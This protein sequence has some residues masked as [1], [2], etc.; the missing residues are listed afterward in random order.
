[1]IRRLALAVALSWGAAA[2]AQTSPIIRVD[3]AG[4]G[5]GPQI[6][7]QALAAPHRVVPPSSERFVFLR[8]STYRPT[9]IVLGRDAVV[10]GRVE[11]DVIIVAGDLY[12]HPGAAITGRVVAIDGGVYESMLATIGGRVSS[13]RHFTYDV[14]PVDGGYSLRYREL[15]P[16][17]DAALT[18]PGIYGLGL[19]SYDRTNGLS[20]GGGPQY[21]VPGTEVVITPELTYRSQLGTIDPSVVAAAQLDRRTVARVRAERTTLSN[22][23]WI[24]ANLLNSALFLF[25]GDDTR[26]YY[27][28]TRALVTVERAWES[29]AGKLVPYVGVLHERA[30]SVRPG[31]F[32][33][34]GPWT[35]LGRKD[36]DRTHRL[37]ENPRVDDDK[38]ITS[39]VAGAAWDWSA[40]ELTA[41]AGA[42]VELGSG[43]GQLTFDGHVEFPTF[44]THALSI[45]AHLVTSAGSRT[46]RQRYAYVGGS[47]TL[48]TLDL[49]SEGG[50]ELFFL[51][52][53]Y[54]IPL[55]VVTLPFFGQP[56]LTLRDMLGGARV[57]GFPTLHQAIGARLAVGPLYAEFLIDPVSRK[58]HP[59]FGLS[60]AR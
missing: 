53:A 43:F 38:R 19:P 45:A 36:E 51:D 56:V 11:G 59:G 57:G 6:L 17:Q 42:D 44:R 3:D 54:A 52:A 50:D 34:G 7:A 15:F 31:P 37:R 33:T 35:M 32:A 21:V 10:E 58:T 29:A 39:A 49:L 28:S 18:W 25:N 27:R 14:T 13:F 40:N 20:I 2:S 48:S 9:T 47:G 1:V 5:V 4:P 16:V 60:L 26:N 41:A 22:D 46:P 8:D 30:G 23:R 12:M 55:N 24:R